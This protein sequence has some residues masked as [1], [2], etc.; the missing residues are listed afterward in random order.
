MMSP[1]VYRQFRMDAPIHVQLRR[2]AVTPPGGGYLHITGRV[3]RIFR[4]DPHALY[5]GK[6]IRFGV[7]MSDPEARE[8]PAPSGT[9]YHSWNHLGRARWVEAFLSFWNGE[10]RL[11]H[12][13][14]AGIRGPT[15]RPLC[16]P[17]AE[18]FCCRG[19]F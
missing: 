19:N 12:S 18:G 2:F 11:V 1:D 10:I 16:D 13:Q 3:W 4:D 8:P 15:W 14:I 17:A 5:W 7:S 9:I 6:A